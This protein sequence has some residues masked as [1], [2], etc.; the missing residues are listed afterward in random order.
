[1]NGWL[2]ITSVTLSFAFLGRWCCGVNPESCGSGWE[3]IC[4]VKGSPHRILKQ[5]LSAGNP[6][7]FGRCSLGRKPE[8]RWN[9]VTHVMD[10]QVCFKM[11]LIFSKILDRIQ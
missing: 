11:L 6:R 4:C 7:D 5:A 8:Y 10:I 1:M 2:L 9:I 3:R